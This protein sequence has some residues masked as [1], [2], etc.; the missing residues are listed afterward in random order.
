MGVG[1]LRKPW[2]SEDEVAWAGLS[3]DV[4]G[5]ASRLEAEWISSCTSTTAI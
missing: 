5:G 4:A 3:V 2:L 1:R